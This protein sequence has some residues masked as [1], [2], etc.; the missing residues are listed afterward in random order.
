MILSTVRSKIS[1]RLSK[2]VDSSFEGNSV[3]RHMRSYYF[4]VNFVL[5]YQIFALF[6]AFE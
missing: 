5:V 4:S 3:K 2:V 1:D 6:L